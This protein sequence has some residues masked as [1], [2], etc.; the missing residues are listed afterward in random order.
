MGHK[1][2]NVSGWV[3]RGVR[4]GRGMKEDGTCGTCA[5]PD[6]NYQSEAMGTNLVYIYGG[7]CLWAPLRNYL[8]RRKRKPFLKWALLTQLASNNAAM[9]KGKR[10]EAW[11]SERAIL[12]GVNSWALTSKWFVGL[13]WTRDPR[14]VFL[15]V[16]QV[17]SC[18][19]QQ[20]NNAAAQGRT[21]C[22]FLFSPLTKPE[23][24]SSTDARQDR[25]T[26]MVHT[27]GNIL[28]AVSRLCLQLPLA[29][30]MVDVRSLP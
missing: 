5:M 19:W 30:F 21:W 11:D 29:I 22:V 10:W 12:L 23:R 14:S 9:K 24:L 16:V 1:C 15:V 28:I 7:C 25:R 27:E 18:I 20:S 8:P 17:T 6:I 13:S 3:S 4:L 2:I 26:A